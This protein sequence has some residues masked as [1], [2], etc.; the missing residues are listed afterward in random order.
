MY[1]TGYAGKAGI[2]PKMEERKE[3]NISGALSVTPKLRTRKSSY[4]KSQEA[5][6]PACPMEFFLVF[7]PSG[8]N[9]YPVKCVAY[10]SWA[11]P[12]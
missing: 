6:Y 5:I 2:V 12:I 3:G 1:Q 9:V 4:N 8:F 11:K 7:I 10:F